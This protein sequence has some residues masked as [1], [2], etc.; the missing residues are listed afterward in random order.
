MVALSATAP[1]A[2]RRT[3]AGATVMPSR[4]SIVAISYLPPGLEDR[5]FLV[6]RQMEHRVA[7]AADLL[8]A[9]VRR[10]AIGVAG[11]GQKALGHGLD[12]RP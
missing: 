1:H 8:G 6:L 3:V 5:K 10:Q 11:V 12:N 9:D 4:N 7:D 2:M